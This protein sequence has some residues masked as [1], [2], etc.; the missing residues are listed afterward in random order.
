MA[1]IDTAPIRYMD[2]AHT[3]V[4]VDFEIGKQ[5]RCYW[6]DRNR[7]KNFRASS[8][9]VCESGFQ[10]E[11]TFRPINLWYGGFMACAFHKIESLDGSWV[12]YPKDV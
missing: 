10:G 9:C 1:D 11:I 12:Y 8:V 5:Y 7:P 4:N 3:Q 6:Y 2:N